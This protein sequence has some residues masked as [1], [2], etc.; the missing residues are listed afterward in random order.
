MYIDLIKNSFRSKEYWFGFLVI[1]I[2]CVL[3]AIYNLTPN[4]NFSEY[5]IGSSE[6]FIAATMFSNMWIRIS[7]PIIAIFV[8]MNRN[9]LFFKNKEALQECWNKKEMK[10]H[11]LAIAAI[12]SS[13]FLLAFFLLL[14]SGIILFPSSTG[15]IQP[16]TGL[17]NHLY[18]ISPI[19]Y[20]LVYIM[21]ACI[22]GAIYSLFGMSIKVFYIQPVNLVLFV[23]LVFYSCFWR[24]NILFPFIKNLIAYI[25]PLYPFDISIID[26][27][28]L[29]RV[30]ELV[31]VLTISITLFIISFYRNTKQVK[32]EIDIETRAESSI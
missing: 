2:S 17:F 19:G 32:R 28:L 8:C 29:E 4:G 23:P 30:V 22:S 14:L 24:L 25:A 6:F 21:N 16:Q 9:S 27:S 15:S 18:S 26:I 20:C 31:F 12:G 3:T 11:I 1:I 7:A 13:V 5:K 10:A